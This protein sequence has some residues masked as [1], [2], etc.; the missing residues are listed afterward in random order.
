MHRISIPVSAKPMTRVTASYI[1]KQDNSRVDWT[2]DVYLIF[3]NDVHIRK[4][5]ISGTYDTASNMDSGVSYKVEY[6]AKNE[7]C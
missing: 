3:D 5:G 1:E 2:A 4:G 6:L 7:L